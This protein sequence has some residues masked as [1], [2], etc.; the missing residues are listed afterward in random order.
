MSVWKPVL[1]VERVRNALATVRA[2]RTLKT[3]DRVLRVRC[4]GGRGT[5]TFIE[6]D[7]PWAQGVSV[8]DCHARNILKVNGQT[9]D[10]AAR[11]PGENAIETRR[12][13]RELMRHNRELRRDRQWW[14]EKGMAV[15][16]AETG[17][18][19]RRRAAT[20]TTDEIPF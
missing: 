20:A 5:F 4:G 16:A 15:R 19:E 10:F 18:R 14:R 7:G 3:G 11:D 13:A 8:T 6:W 2:Q 9:V 12:A 17:Q 1:A